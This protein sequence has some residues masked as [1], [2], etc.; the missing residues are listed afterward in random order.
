MSYSARESYLAPTATVESKQRGDG[1]AFPAAIKSATTVEGSPPMNAALAVET[2]F[3]RRGVGLSSRI[4]RL[5]STDE[6]LHDGGDWPSA[7]PRDVPDAM[8]EDFDL[9]GVIRQPDRSID[10]MPRRLTFETPAE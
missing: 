5:A 6:S 1:G 7:C 3:G 8:G 10:E 9:R 2:H 4:R